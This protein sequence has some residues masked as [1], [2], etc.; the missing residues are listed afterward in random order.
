MYCVRVIYILPYFY[1]KCRTFFKKTQNILYLSAIFTER[2]RLLPQNRG[3]S[4]KLHFIHSFNA[5]M[6]NTQGI[7]YLQRLK[8]PCIKII[9]DILSPGITRRPLGA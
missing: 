5:F 2:G 7:L 1:G 3:F 6:T 8:S 9:L 4:E